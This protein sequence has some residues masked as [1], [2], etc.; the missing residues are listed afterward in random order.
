VNP[1]GTTRPLTQGDGSVVR[2]PKVDKP[3]NEFQG[4]STLYGTRAAQSDKILRTLEDGIS[5][6]GLAAKLAVSKT[7]VIGGVLGAAGNVMLSG[8]QQRVEQ[9]QRDFVNAVLRQ[10]S[11]AVISDAEF[12]NAQKQYFPQPGDDKA[13]KDQKR[14]NRA[15][16]ITG[17]ARMA[18]PG[19]EDINTIRS[20]PLL[21]GTTRGIR[22]TPPP[23]P[24][25]KAD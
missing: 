7:P 16:A 17:F 19:A 22:N 18:G 15:L 11:G 25:F 10:E 6:S 1:D 24:G 8:E 20:A 13:T 23:P 9:A 5:T 2:S 12:A 21:P 14:A 3:L 4:K